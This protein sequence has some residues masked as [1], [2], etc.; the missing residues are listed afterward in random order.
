MALPYSYTSFYDTDLSSSDFFIKLK[1]ISKVASIEDIFLDKN[2][3]S[4]N[5]NS[6]LCCSGKEI[7]LKFRSDNSGFFYEF[8]LE[9]LIKVSIFVILIL[10]FIVRGFENLLIYFSVVVVL[11]YVVG[12]YHFKSVLENI[13]DK[14]ALSKEQPE[15]LSEEQ[16]KW[17][18]NPDVC[19]ACGTELTAYDAVCPECGLNLKTYR[20]SKKQPVSRTGFETYRIFYRFKSD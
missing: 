18:K 20:K 14:I 19:P 2:V 16:Q 4:F 10:A 7:V 6:F 17:L 13:F 3:I 11:L 12:I 8:S 15:E 1:K 9:S 5:I